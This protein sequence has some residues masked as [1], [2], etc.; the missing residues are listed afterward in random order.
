MLQLILAIFLALA[1]HHNNTAPS[2][3]SGTQ[4]SAQDTGGETEPIPPKPPKP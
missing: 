1:P 4:I 2:Q 3:S